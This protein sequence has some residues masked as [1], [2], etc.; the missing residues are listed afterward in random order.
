MLLLSFC[1]LPHKD[2]D[3]VAIVISILAPGEFAANYFNKYTL[4]DQI[5]TQFLLTL[6]DKISIS[7]FKEMVSLRL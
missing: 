3:V 4:I 6:K 7:G 2:I 5:S 1:F